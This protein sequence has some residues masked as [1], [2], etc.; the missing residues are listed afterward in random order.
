MAKEK[1]QTF[2]N[3]V[4]WVPAY[5]FVALPIFAINVFWSLVRVFASFSFESVL[6]LLVAVA[7]LVLCLGARIFTVTVQDRVIRLEMRLRLTRLLPPDLQ[8]RVN[9]FTVSQLV[10]LR[11]S[12][13]EE[14]PELARKVLADNLADRKAIKQ[15][16]R[17]WQPDI[18]R[19]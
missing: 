18:L 3:H 2:E 13:D 8:P 15:M 12:S 16:I 19:A 7:L 11:F 1:P 4:R 17:S 14:L 5:H 10:S 6:A 9:D